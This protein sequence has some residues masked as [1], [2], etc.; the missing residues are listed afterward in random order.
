MASLVSEVETV[1]MTRIL[2]LA[3]VNIDGCAIGIRAEDGTPI[4]VEHEK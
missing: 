1:R 2:Q 4:V 3:P